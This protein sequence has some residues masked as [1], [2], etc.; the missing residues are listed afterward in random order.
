MGDDQPGVA[1]SLTGPVGKVVGSTRPQFSW[2][3][4][5]DADSYVVKIFDA[6]FK[7]IAESPPLRSTNW[8]PPVQLAHGSAYRWQVTAIKDGEE[9]V[10]PVRPAPDARFKVIDAAAANEIAAAKRIKSHLVLGITY[11]NAGLIDEAEREFQALAKQ[12]PRSEV[13]KGLLRKVRA[14]R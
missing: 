11:A 5:K 14:A 6:K 10:S 12:N 4:L 1:F 8:V 2:K 13:V 9:V 7:S 3:P